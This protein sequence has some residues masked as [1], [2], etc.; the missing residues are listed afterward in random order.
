MASARARHMVLHAPLRTV[1]PESAPVCLNERA[2]FVG[3]TRLRV[4][5]A[6]FAT[7]PVRRAAPGAAC[8]GRL[9][10]LLKQE[11]LAAGTLRAPGRRQCA[12]RGAAVARASREPGG[13]ETVRTHG[14]V[15]RARFLLWRS[16]SGPA[17]GAGELPGGGSDRRICLCVWRRCLR[18][19]GRRLGAQPTL[20]FRVRSAA[21]ASALRRRPSS[22][23]G[24]CSSSRCRW[25]TCLCLCCSLVTS[26]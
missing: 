22:L 10:P 6:R 20:P 16:F 11:P 25:T 21:Y 7:Q 12:R 3:C 2:G 23:R 5:R 18:F 1:L 15:S 13:G 19:Q 9:P 14:R 26:R 17:A 24:I 8:P 4:C